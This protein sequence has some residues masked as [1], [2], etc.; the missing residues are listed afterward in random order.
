LPPVSLSLLIVS[1]F[2]HNY[3]NSTAKIAYP[4]LGT[5]YTKMISI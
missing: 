1:R 5:A 2:S 4:S 3:G